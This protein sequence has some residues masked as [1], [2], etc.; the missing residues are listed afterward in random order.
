MLTAG[1]YEKIGL[2]QKRDGNIVHL[3]LTRGVSRLHVR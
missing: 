1:Q 3:A 2:T